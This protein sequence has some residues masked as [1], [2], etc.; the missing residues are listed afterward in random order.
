MIDLELVCLAREALGKGDVFQALEHLDSF[1]KKNNYEMSE[2]YIVDKVREIRRTKYLTEVKRLAK[3]L[4]EEWKAGTYSGHRE[5]FDNA[6]NGLSFVSLY[7]EAQDTLIFGKADTDFGAS[8]FNWQYGIPWCELAYYQLQADIL[9]ALT[10]DYHI[11]PNKTPP[12]Q[13]AEWCGSCDEWLPRNTVIN[14]PAKTVLKRKLPMATK[15]AVERRL[16]LNAW[17]DAE[18]FALSH[19][20]L[21]LSAADINKLLGLIAYVKKLKERLKNIPK[22]RDNRLSF[23]S[24]ADYSATYCEPL[25]NGNRTFEPP[26]T[27]ALEPESMVPLEFTEIR[28]NCDSIRVS[29][30]AVYWH[31]CLHYGD[32]NNVW[33]ADLTEK[34]LQGY[35]QELEVYSAPGRSKAQKGRR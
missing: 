35:L 14:G 6:L 28:T 10:D 11:N 9:L 21:W 19:A 31:A 30:T 32:A 26:D 8:L 20:C 12:R 34:D 24:F 17:C 13:A 4:F 16:I 22:Y 27:S 5:V 33:T 3:Q 2:Q 7:E 29:A 23:L 15:P 25:T 1:Q 18:G